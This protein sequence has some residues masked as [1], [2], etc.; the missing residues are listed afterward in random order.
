MSKLLKIALLSLLFLPSLAFAEE[1]PVTDFTYILNSFSFLISGVLVMWMAAGFAML[2]SGLVQTKNVA[3]I[4]LKNIAIFAI[5]GILYNLVGYNLMYSGVDGGFIGSLGMWVANDAPALA[6]DFSLGYSTGSDWF[7]QMVFVATAASVVSGTVAERIKLWP[8]LIFCAVLTGIIYPIQ[9]SWT[10][11][12]GW[13]SELGFSDYAGSSIVHSVGGWSALT[14]AIILG[15]RRGKYK[16]GRINPIPGSNLTLATLGTF[17]LWMGWFGF[18]GGSAL[19]LGTVNSVIEQSSV[20]INTNLGACGGLIASMILLQIL[21]KKTD[22]TMSLNGALAGLVSITAGP[23][24]PSSIGAI[25][26]GAVGGCLVVFA[27]PLFDKLK[28]DD[29]V[30]ALSVHLVC[31]IWGTLAVPFADKEA[32]FLIQLLGVVSIGAFV[33]VCSALVWLILKYTVG[34]RVS[35][36]EEYAGSDTVELGLEAYPEFGHGSSGVRLG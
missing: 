28:I 4:C 19:A 11:G 15:A 12:G 23:A 14:G 10:W 17:I 30:G 34:I 32:S 22:L 3:I 33:T 9:G 31:G 1:A 36:E 6:G 27:V 25:L 5:A 24:A 21:Y 26:I 2:E 35:E 18:N 8:F 7:F 16:G 13:L 20:Y 29:V